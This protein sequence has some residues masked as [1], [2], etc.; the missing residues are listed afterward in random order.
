MALSMTIYCKFTVESA[1][2]RILKSVNLWRS[3]SQAA[4]VIV[5]R[6][7]CAWAL[8]C[9][10]M[11]ISQDTGILNMARNSWVYGRPGTWSSIGR[12]PSC[13]FKSNF[14]PS[15]KLRGSTCVGIPTFM[16][17]RWT[18]A[19]LWWFNDIMAVRHLGFLEF[20]FY[21]ISTVQRVNM[22][23]NAKVRGD[24][25]NRCWDMAILRFFKTVALRHLGFWK[26]E[27]LIVCRLKRVKMRHYTKFNSCPLTVA[28]L[29]RFNC[30]SRWRPSAILNLKK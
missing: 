30:F 22:R 3:N 5:S 6:A 29:W 12:P 27:I 10:G 23:H 15:L 18:A 14:C 13:F 8:S 26:I 25:S 21:T 2:E 28:E 7:L 19:E 16:V 4:R 17:I 24:R 11:K 9:W 1:Y 20:D